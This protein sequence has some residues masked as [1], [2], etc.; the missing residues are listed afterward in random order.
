MKNFMRIVLA[1]LA[2]YFLLFA[3]RAIYDLATFEDT[4]HNYNIYYESERMDSKLLNVASFRQEYATSV[5][6]EVLDQKYEKIATL[7][8]NS[9]RFDEEEQN[10]RN[11]IEES[12][13]VVQMENRMG[14]EGARRLRMTIGVRPEYFE[15]AVERIEQIGRI[16][17]FTTTTTDKTYEYRQMLAEKEKLL[18][19]KER[20]EAL[21]NRGGNITEL[22][23]VEDRII[24]VETLL[25]HQS[26]ML[27]DYSDDNALCTI[28]FTMHEG[29]EAGILRK[30]WNAFV[31]STLAY[32]SF[33]GI[34]LFTCGVAYV[35]LAVWKYGKTAIEKTTSKPKGDS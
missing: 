15:A 35:I 28:N 2:V 33:L 3:A 30:L 21:K 23:V 5:G 14:L 32:L 18:N 19:Q 1:L 10:L 22:L 24:E 16:T 9:I 8:S 7:V 25:Q 11:A 13:A 31:W 4:D 17:S 20:Y 27:G 34:L 26:V 29:N 12:L 6:V